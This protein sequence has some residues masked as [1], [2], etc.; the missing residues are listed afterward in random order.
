VFCGLFNDADW[1]TVDN[2]LESC[3]GIVQGTISGGTA[4]KKKKKKKLC[5][6]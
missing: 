3:G 4:E 5:S 1:I 2:V 6:G